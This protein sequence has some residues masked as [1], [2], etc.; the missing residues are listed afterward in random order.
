MNM[1][2]LLML[3]LIGIVLITLGLMGLYVDVNRRLIAIK[4]SLKNT[5]KLVVVQSRRLDVIEQRDREAAEHIYICHDDSDVK[6]GG[7]GI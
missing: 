4:K 1:R 5:N 6:F 7:E 2:I 3:T